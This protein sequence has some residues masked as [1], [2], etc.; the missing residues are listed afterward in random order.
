VDPATGVPGEWSAARRDRFPG[1]SGGRVPVAP[2]IRG[3]VSA[4]SPPWPSS[5]TLSGAGRDP[6]RPAAIPADEA[7]RRVRPGS[8]IGRNLLREASGREIPDEPETRCGRHSKVLSGPRSCGA[9]T[10][11]RAA[12]AR[13]SRRPRRTSCVVQSRSRVARGLASRSS[14][15]GHSVTDHRNATAPHPPDGEPTRWPPP[16]CWT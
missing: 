8:G 1:G 4:R 12:F 14:G 6:C 7:P 11:S 5:D 3:I 15:P 9:R 10:R 16:C 13:A 2:V